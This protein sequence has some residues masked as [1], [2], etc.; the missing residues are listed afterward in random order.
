MTNQALAKRD[1]LPPIFEK[2]RNP[3]NFRSNNTLSRRQINSVYHGTES[4]F[5]LG[6]NICVMVPSEINN[7]KGLN[8]LKSKPKIGFLLS[9][10]VDCVVH[11]SK[12]SML[13]ENLIYYYHC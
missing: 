7:Q 12:E 2:R 6:P 8:F 3:Y 1:D 10:P 9:G 13:Y 4:L 5:F 11:T